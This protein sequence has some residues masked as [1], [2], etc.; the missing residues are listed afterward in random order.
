MKY[1]KDRNLICAVGIYIDDIILASDSLKEIEDAK[2]TLSQ[3]FEMTDL[4][5]ISWILRMEVKRDREHKTMTISQEKYINDILKRYGQLDACPITTLS[6]PNEQLIKLKSPEPDVD[7]QWYQS[8]VGA[9]MYAMLGTRPDLAYTVGILSQH[10]AAPGKAHVHA[11]QHTFQYLHATI[12]HNLTFNGN[13]CGELI[14]FSDADWAANVNDR[15]SISSYVFMLSGAAV[16]WS[17][18]K[19]GATALSSMEAEYITGAHAA[20]E[21][22]WLRTLLSEFGELQ[23]APTTLLI[24]NQ[25][26]IAI[27]K[28]LAYHACTKHIDVRYHFLHEKYASRELEL[29]CIPTGEQLADVL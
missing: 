1:D 24:D 11:V 29:Q 5:E 15:H 13:E 14:G 7:V 27:A 12:H 19:Q 25:S 8:A 26:A 6:L 3:T 16:S 17:S 21:A 23:E 9:L 28:S 2:R 20:K 18:K 10:T 22:V 4:G